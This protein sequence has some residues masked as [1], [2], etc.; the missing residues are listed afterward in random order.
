[1]RNQL[2][3]LRFEEM[4]ENRDILTLEQRQQFAQLMQQRRAKMRASKGWGNGNPQ[5]PDLMPLP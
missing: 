3:S 2:A 5:D 1:L 4:L